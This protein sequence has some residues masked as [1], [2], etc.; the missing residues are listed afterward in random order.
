MHI[1]QSF[2]ERSIF[3]NLKFVA[4][5]S[6]FQSASLHVLTEIIPL[7]TWT[8]LGTLSTTENH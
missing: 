6:S 3:A 4:Q 8:G 7:G 2:P 5:G 1:S